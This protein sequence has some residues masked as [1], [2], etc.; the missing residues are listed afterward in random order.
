MEQKFLNILVVVLLV[1]II[2][3][4]S[5]AVVQQMSYQSLDAEYQ[6]L[7]TDYETLSSEWNQT[8]DD[9]NDLQSEFETMQTAYLTLIEDYDSLSEM[10]LIAL[11]NSTDLQQ[12]LDDLQEL[13]DQ[14]LEDFALLNASFVELEQNYA[15]LQADYAQLQSDYN[16]LQA[17]Y[18]Q[19]LLDY[20]DL[21][22]QHQALQDS[23][24]ALVLAYD[25]LELQYDALVLDHNTLLA[26]YNTLVDDFLALQNDYDV[27]ELSYNTLA[28]W[29][30]QQILPAQYMVFAEAVRRYYFEDF[31]ILSEDSLGYWPEFTLFCRDVILHDSQIG[32]S[33]LAGSWFPDVSNALADCLRY[34]SQTEYLAYQNFYWVF[35]DWIPN[36]AGFALPSNRLSAIAQV[37]Q[38][39]IDNI[40]Y[41]LDSDITRYRE[42]YSWDY[43]KFPVETAFRAMGDCEDQAMLT[44]A[45]L[46]SCGFETM[47][48]IIH[49]PEWNGGEGLYHGVPMIWWDN[50]WP[51]TRPNQWG[52]S[53]AGDGA[54][55][56]D[57]WWMFLDTTWNTPFGTD[58]AWLQ[59]YAVTDINRVFNAEAFSYAVCDHNGWPSCTP[60]GE[61]ISVALEA[62]VP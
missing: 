35:Y 26:D 60:S 58:P 56:N 55:Y 57:G 41:E 46:E 13:Y 62:Y 34:G 14:L 21:M 31:Y 33:P 23:Y 53:F 59:W 10:Y 18:N 39:C 51:E 6:D 9:L 5:V 49:D 38:W 4:S 37:T 32:Y 61:A 2:G 40:E 36:W 48:V 17:N 50:T 19:L 11:S 28:T 45:Y 20:N 44:A 47:M 16:E 12:S 15:D 1:G 52:F 22:A 54:K 8:S 25:T 30:R 42:P 43:I 3:V 7:L 29:I 24:N 27:L